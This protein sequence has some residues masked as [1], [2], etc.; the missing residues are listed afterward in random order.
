MREIEP[1][2]D[3]AVGES[4][5]S[6]LR[7]LQFLRRELVA[8][9]GGAGTARLTRGA[10]FLTGALRPGSHAERIKHLNSGAKWCAGVGHAPM[11]AQ[12]SAVGKL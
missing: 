2:A 3:L 12:P 6:H 7:Y 5:R 4:P 1:L 8:R 10:Q 9:F 11:T